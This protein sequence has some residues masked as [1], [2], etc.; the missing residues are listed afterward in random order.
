MNTVF[1]GGGFGKAPVFGN[2]LELLKD[3]Y[4]SVGFAD[5]RVILPIISIWIGCVSRWW[6][7]EPDESEQIIE[8]CA[9]FDIKKQTRRHLVVYMAEERCCFHISLR[10][11]QLLTLT[12]R[13]LQILQ[14]YL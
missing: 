2:H 4:Q 12:E 5:F 6:S 8:I 7:L 3:F 11:M 9:K 1:G 10:C 14:L 13:I